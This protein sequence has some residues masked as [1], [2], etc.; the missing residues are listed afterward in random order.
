MGTDL[1]REFLNSIR[2]ILIEI[3]ANEYTF[4]T[5]TRNYN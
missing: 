4:N 1:K 2:N 5:K 3:L